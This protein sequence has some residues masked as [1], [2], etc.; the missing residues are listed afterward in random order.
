[1]CGKKEVGMSRDSLYS[2]M[3]NF[4]TKFSL[5]LPSVCP[6]VHGEPLNGSL[7]NLVL[8]S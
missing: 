6:C 2:L 5:I 7:R 1:M 8:D 4:Y 3:R